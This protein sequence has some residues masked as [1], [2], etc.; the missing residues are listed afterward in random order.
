MQMA[1]QCRV[2]NQYTT[3]IRVSVVVKIRSAASGTACIDP[4]IYPSRLRSF[5]LLL[6]DSVQLCN[7][8]QLFLGIRLFHRHEA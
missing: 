4:K 1:Q 3:I 7:N 2:Q 5:S 8:H 6:E